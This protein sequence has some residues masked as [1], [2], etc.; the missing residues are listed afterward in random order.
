VEQTF[1]WDDEKAAS[2]LRKHGISFEEASTV[3]YGFNSIPL[4]DEE[5]S[6]G[7]ERYIEIGYSADGN[8]LFVVYTERNS[9]LR[10]ISARRCTLA[11][12]KW[13]DANK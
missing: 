11:E 7:E 2:N 6:F 9:R 12:I 8:L 5:H 3:F 4:F 13:Y 1:E 10:L